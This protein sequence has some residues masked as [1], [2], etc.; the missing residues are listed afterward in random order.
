MWT[1][2]THNVSSWE[3]SKSP[4]LEGSAFFPQAVPP[5]GYWDEGF[6]YDVGMRENYPYR[7]SAL[8][9]HINSVLICD[10]RTFWDPSST[11]RVQQTD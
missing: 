11:T 5:H 6:G 2:F 10:I 3:V 4:V 7:F 9:L 8:A 1:H